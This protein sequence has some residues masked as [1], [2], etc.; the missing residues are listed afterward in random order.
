[1]ACG[2]RRSQLRWPLDHR[3]PRPSLLGGALQ[4]LTVPQRARF[5][6][7]IQTLRGSSGGVGGTP[8]IALDTETTG[9]GQNAGTIAFL[10]GIAWFEEEVLVVEQWTLTQ[11]SAEAAMLRSLCQQL[12]V[13]AGPSTV[14]LT[15]NGASFDLPLLRARCRRHDL[16]STALAASHVDLLLPARRLWREQMPD[17]RLA[18]LERTCLGVVR[19][20][21]IGGHA[22]PQAYWSWLEGPEEP[23][24][25]ATL[26]RVHVHNQVDLLTLPALAAEIVSVIES[27]KDVA[28]ALRVARLQIA[29][30]DQDAALRVL[31]KWLPAAGEARQVDAPVEAVVRPA[32]RHALGG[33]GERMLRLGLV[34]GGRGGP[35]VSRLRALDDVERR[36]AGVGVPEERRGASAGERGGAGP[37]GI[38]GQGARAGGADLGPEGRQAWA[39]AAKLLRRRGDD[40]Q[41]ATIWARLCDLRPGDPEAHEALAK[42]LEHRLQDLPRALR[43]ACASSSPCPRRVAR[44]RRKLAKH[45]RR[46]PDSVYG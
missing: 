9:L 19:C 2:F 27:P 46:E 35:V 29:R 12:D 33:I 34:A 23:E 21:D 41:S 4:D 36:R 11:L 30:G 18:T 44:L 25:S 40:A 37:A 14:L 6:E 24:A 32:H 8:M 22:I 28:Q 38:T 7:L 1:M 39:L 45:S 5:S 43:V 20:D 17:C 31:E 15:F 26:Q 10:V 42:L 16:S 3:A 13:L